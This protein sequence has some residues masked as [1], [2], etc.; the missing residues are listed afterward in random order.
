VGHYP[1]R[2]FRLLRS[3]SY[4]ESEWPVDRI[5]P[6]EQERRETSVDL[7][8]GGCQLKI[9]Q[10][11]EELNFFSLK[12]PNSRAARHFPPA[13][14]ESAAT[15]ALTVGPMRDLATALRWLLA[16]RVV[17]GFPLP[18][19]G[20][21]QEVTAMMMTLK[22]P[23]TWVL[24]L[25]GL[26]EGTTKRLGRFPLA[27]LQLIFR[28]SIASVFFKSGHSKILSWDTTILLFANEYRVPVLGPE[29]AAVL[30]ASC[31]LGCSVLIFLGLMT[32]LATV[33][34]LGMVFVIQTFVYPENWVEHLTWAAMLVFLLTRGPGP[35][36]FDHLLMRWLFENKAAAP[37][38]LT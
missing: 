26:V 37:L 10:L 11:S 28:F 33:P 15:A 13:R 8:K 6:G 7:G 16:N 9:R 14:V 35:I 34:L 17:A 5:W 18:A 38:T 21:I 4:L 27:I 23:D 12:L 31:E 30:A 29:V 2:V 24:P 25:W 20:L 3:L 19:T 1:H 22:E 36:S 32:R